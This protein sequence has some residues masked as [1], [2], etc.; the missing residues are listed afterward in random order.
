MSNFIQTF[1]QYLLGEDRDEDEKEKSRHARMKR[2][3]QDAHQRVLSTG[4][5]EGE[6]AEKVRHRSARRSEQQRHVGDHRSK[7]KKPGRHTT[8]YEEYDNE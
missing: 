2:R 8:S 3:E 1:S 5:R 4:D 6:E 7:Y